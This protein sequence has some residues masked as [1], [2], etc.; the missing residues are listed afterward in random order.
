MIDAVWPA[1]GGWR[2]VALILGGSL[3]IALAAQV[4]VLLPFSPVPLTAQTF[5]VL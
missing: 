3:L 1:A 2:D 4:Q 5:A